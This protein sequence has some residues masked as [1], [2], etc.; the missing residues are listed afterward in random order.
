MA[1]TTVMKILLRSK[2]IV[3][4]AKEKGAAESNGIWE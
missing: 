3:A 2:N 4:E 1:V